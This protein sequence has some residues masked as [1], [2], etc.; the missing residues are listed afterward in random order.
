MGEQNAI[1]GNDNFNDRTESIKIS[2]P[3]QWLLYEHENFQGRSYI[4]NPGNYPS[5]NNWGGPGSSISSA[6]A[7]P[8]PGTKAIALFDDDEFRGRMALSYSTR[9]SLPGIDFNDRTSSFIITGG[10]WTLY[11]GTAFRGGSVTYGPGQYFKASLDRVGGVN[12]ISSIK[13]N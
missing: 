10:S 12:V 2:G 4:V 8:A 1:F 5:S 6:R 13:L 9:S 7:L 11:S 3:C